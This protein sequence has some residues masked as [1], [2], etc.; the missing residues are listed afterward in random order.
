M[1]TLLDIP[2]EIEEVYCKDHF[3]PLLY[4]CANL[5]K[6]TLSE[7][8]I[9]Q[10]YALKDALANSKGYLHKTTNNIGIRKRYEYSDVFAVSVYMEPLEEKGMYSCKLGEIVIK[11]TE[12]D[13]EKAVDTYVMNEW[14]G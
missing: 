9:S 10:I 7:E 5:C 3:G 4:L 1:K 13:I 2:E 12:S 11:G 8:S 14:R 6:D